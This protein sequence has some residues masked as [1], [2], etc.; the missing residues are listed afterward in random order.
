MYV[1]NELEK[2]NEFNLFYERFDSDSTKNDECREILNSVV[3]DPNKQ[4][5]VIEQ[6]DVA[7]VFKKLCIKKSSGPDLISA[8]ILKTFADELTPVW[9]PL[10]QRSVD[11]GSIPAIWKK[12]ISIPVAKTSCPKENN[13]FRPVA[14]TSIV[15]KSL[16]RIM[17]GKSCA[18]VE[19]LLDPHQFAYNRGRGTDDALNS[20]TH[21]M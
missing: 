5:I 16:E 21:L 9:C 6:R 13:D 20:T 14:Q 19:H 2:A 17:V 7:N 15:M 10:F 12:A 4:R 3:C 1:Y 8:L 18:E 11:S